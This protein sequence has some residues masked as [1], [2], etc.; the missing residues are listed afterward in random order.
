MANLNSSDPADNKAHQ[1]ITLNSSENW[2]IINHSLQKQLGLQQAV[3]AYKGIGHAVYEILYGTSSYF[4]HK[5]SIGFVTGSTPIFS[6]LMPYF[7]RETYEVQKLTIE[8]LADIE[9]IKA[10]VESLKKDTVFVA[11]P[12]NHPF[13]GEFW[14]TNLLDELLNQKKIYSVAISHSLFGLDKLKNLKPY[15][16][17]ICSSNSNLAFASGGERFRTPP[18]LA[19][20]L[21][22]DSQIKLAGQ[23]FTFFEDQALIQ[24]FEGQFKAN[25]LQANH[26]LF[27]QQQRS[28][29]RSVVI[30]NDVNGEALLQML[31]QK[32]K[33]P[34]ERGWT[35]AT[36][37]NMCHWTGFQLFDGWTK[38]TDNE[39]R[40]MCIFSLELLKQNDMVSKLKE[41]Y[42]ELKQKQ[43]W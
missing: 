13:T 27:S 29:D 39:L 1:L 2:Y 33:I 23:D 22:W 4:S 14:D 28:F 35:L 36:T 31:F 41:T 20:D 25:K 43:Q 30:F 21:P 17:Q 18:V 37:P 5:K 7:L 6:S 19:L 42:H 34:K 10:W 26:F 9:K 24:N 32:L 3:R 15:S 12:M 8:D 16:I 38:F 40:G 11:Y